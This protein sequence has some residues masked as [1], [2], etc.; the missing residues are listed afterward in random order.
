MGHLWG[1]MS[2]PVRLDYMVNGGETARNMIRKVGWNQ[3]MMDLEG[4]VT[5]LW[6]EVTNDSGDGCSVLCRIT[7]ALRWRSWKEVGKE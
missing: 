7:W 6:D 3:I 4:R 2:N 5:L 1:R